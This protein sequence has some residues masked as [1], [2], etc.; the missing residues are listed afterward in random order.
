MQQELKL[1]YFQTES[2]GAVD[3]PGIRFV[4]FCQGCIYRCLFC[5][6]PESWDLRKKV[7]KF[8]VDEIIEKYERNKT[9]Y[10]TG[11]I[12][13]SGGDPVL[14]IDFLIS[15]AA[16]CN[17]KG[18]HLAI[19]TSGVN[20]GI[21]NN[22]KYKELCKYKPLW[23]VDIKHI[24]PAKHQRLTGV[25]EQRE[26]ELI[27]FL[28]K[29]KQKFWIRQVLV[30]GYTDDPKDLET[31]GKFLKK[32]KGLENFQILPYH[33]LGISKYDTLGYRYPLAGVQEPSAKDIEKAAESINKGYSK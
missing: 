30:P 6:N 12:T 22:D 10:K 16:K 18:I 32:L 20:F 33:R 3:G 1:P 9:F 24:N 21:E 19:D 29:N 15:L 13:I 31:L 11:G 23:I 8:S 4:V 14:Y 17:E 2:F 27:K 28:D 25:K 26:V 7:N 5:H